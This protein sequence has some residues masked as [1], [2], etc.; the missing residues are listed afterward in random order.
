[1]D[2]EI[3]N[4]CVLDKKEHTSSLFPSAIFCKMIKPWISLDDL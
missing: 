2:H 1:M 4:K 3:G